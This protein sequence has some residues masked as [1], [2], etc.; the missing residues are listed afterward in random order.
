LLRDFHSPETI[1]GKTVSR[2]GIN[3]V[4]TKQTVNG[5]EKLSRFCLGN[6]IFYTCRSPVKVGSA[7]ENWDYLAGAEVEELRDVGKNFG[8]RAFTS[9]TP[10]GQCG[11][12]R[13][14]LTID[15]NGEVLMCA[16]AREN[17][18]SIGN[19]NDKSL[20]QLIDTRNKMF[21]MNSESGYCFVKDHRNPEKSI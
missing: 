16:D 14:G 3:S 17:F 7:N 2:L 10:K 4:V 20:T 21:P 19:V 8:T 9:A 12:Y 5:I 1:N 15:N 6:K 13:Y 11:L 18:G